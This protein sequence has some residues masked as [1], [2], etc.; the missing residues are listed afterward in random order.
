MKKT[1]SV[2]LMQLQEFFKKRINDRMQSG[3]ISAIFFLDV[4]CQ[5]LHRQVVKVFTK[6]IFNFFAASKVQSPVVYAA[7]IRF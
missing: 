1:N 2:L 3:K 6:R 7:P 4:V 5:A